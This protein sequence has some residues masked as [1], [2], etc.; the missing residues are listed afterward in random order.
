MDVKQIYSIVNTITEEITGETGLVQEDLGN[1]VDIG[2]TIFNATSVDRYVK[3]MVNT[4]GKIIFTNKVYRGNAPSV[5]MDNWTFGSVV[6]KVT[7]Q[8]PEAMEDERWELQDG[9]S[10]DQ[11]IFYQPVVTV[12]FFNEYTAF[13]IPI[14][15]A[16]DRA[17]QSFNSVA[18]MNNFVSMINTAVE[19]SLTVKVQALIMRTINNFIGATLNAEYPDTSTTDYDDTSTVKAVNLLYLYNQTVTTPI[20]KADAI[21]N[22]DFIRFAVYIMGMYEK[23]MSS[24]STLFNLNGMQKFTPADR[25]K[26]VMHSAFANAAT[27]FLESDTYH[28]NLVALPAADI[29]PYWQGSG[30]SFDFADTSAIDI[31]LKDGTE[32][33]IDGIIA[34]AY[35]YEALGVSLYDR[36]V[37][38]HYNAKGDFINNYHKQAARYFNDYNENFVVFFIA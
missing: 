37:T 12:K 13:E 8:L 31:K 26:W 23:N 34:V 1:I 10:Y 20:T 14:S 25:L 9:A 11:D 16:E 2:T 30:D 22:K 19:N 17:I 35:D 24:M 3:A 28:N 7:M 32:I 33:D 36:K 15:I 29:V 5:Y 4:I 38:S 6:E 27:V 18:D 21:Y